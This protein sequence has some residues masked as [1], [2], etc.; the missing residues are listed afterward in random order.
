M[1]DAESASVLRAVLRDIKTRRE[2]AEA[3]GNG[4][5]DH[6]SLVTDTNA[7]LLAALAPAQLALLQSASALV[8]RRQSDGWRH[9]KCVTAQPSGR[10]FF[11]VESLNRYQQRGD[12]AEDAPLTASALSQP[13]NAASGDAR[14]G[15]PHYYN[16]LP[17]YCSCQGF[18]ERTVAQCPT[19][20]VRVLLLLLL[21]GGVG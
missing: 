4:G 7:Q 19:A 14:A 11:R 18:H 10:R 2:H 20:M 8:H 17:H 15:L 13:F 12:E 3:A 21:R 16:V 5:G 1:S 9:V 6:H